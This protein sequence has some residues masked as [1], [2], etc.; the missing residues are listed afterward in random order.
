M[1]ERKQPPPAAPTT[2]SSSRA[3]NTEASR[4][5]LGND[6]VAS[7]TLNN[8]MASL[9]TKT[10]ELIDTAIERSQAAKNEL[11][12]TQFERFNANLE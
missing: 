12:M 2:R 11:I 8:T 4:S 5:T 9:R 3:T 7:S 1:S 6:H 10:V